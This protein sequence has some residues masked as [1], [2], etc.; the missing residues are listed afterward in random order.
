VSE[1]DIGKIKNDSEG[2]VHYGDINN[3]NVYPSAKEPLAQVVTI[4]SAPLPATHFVGRETELSYIREQ[5][6]QNAKLMLVNGLG[7]IGKSEICK[8]LFHDFGKTDDKIKHLGWIVFDESM[9]KTLYA[10][11]RKT[12]DTTD[13]EE[14]FLRT[15]LHIN[16]LST[17]LLLF[18]D[19]MNAISAEDRDVL[20]SL[21]C[22]IIITS[23]LTT[24]YDNI[25]TVSIGKL[26]E[27]DCIR[28][29]KDI[30]GRTSYDDEVI[31]QIV[32]RADCLTLVVALLAKT[33]KRANLAD[34]KLLEKLNQKGFDLSEVRHTIADGK[35]FNEHLALLFDL[36][37]ISEEE[38]LVLKQFSLFPPQPLEFVYADKWFGQDNPDVLNELADKGWLIKT[39]VGFYMHQV[40][41][42]VVW[43]EN[44]PS[45]LE[46][47]GLVEMV[48]KS[49][50]FDVTDLFTS[51]LPILPFGEGVAE[52]FER[53]ENE[54]IAY[55]LHNIARLHN[56][57][58]DYPI[59]LEWYHKAVDI[60]EKILGEKHPN[61][62]AAYNNIG[63]TH[64]AQ[65]DY[66][67]ALEWSH[68]ALDV[69]EK[70]LGKGHPNTAASYNN[71]A[72]I[73]KRQGD[74]PTALKWFLK[75]LKIN[76]KVLGKEHPDTATT[77]NNIGS[78]YFSQ[79]DCR[80]LA[81]FLKAL[82]IRVKVLGKGHSDTAT[83]Y[84]NIATFYYALGDYSEAFEWCHIALEI[85]EKVLGK[86][87]PST[88]RT[89]NDMLRIS[90]MI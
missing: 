66:P 49:L 46:C 27:E 4:D 65:G 38:L 42:D 20:D 33:A 2:D 54:A 69:Y 59:A 22:N 55:L 82:E 53:E 45:Y 5:I 21:D 89:F 71:I 39:D 72:L 77:Y 28:I 84:N 37:K 8:K 80:A 48:G 11:F 78:V 16:E 75:S 6:A 83:T 86:E 51:R 15:K 3:F 7:G 10:K 13:L 58:G 31:R 36:S 34:W 79:G 9:K 85:K 70:A 14:N 44:E 57:Q 62:A 23:R 19:N 32:R 61:T 52:Y 90:E 76:E 64:F 50:D 87:H 17:K 35:K 29:Y 56:S 26:P 24:D 81:W 47:A 43:Y 68:K 12:L 67:K 18:I 40:I 60:C 74:Y 30:L 1:Y 63:S 25:E 73:H 88:I 41:S